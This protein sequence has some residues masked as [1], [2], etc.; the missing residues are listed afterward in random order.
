MKALRR[1]LIRMMGLITRHRDERRLREEVE[2]HLALQTAEN[3]KAGMCPDEARR[4][5]ILKFGAIEAVKESYRD[6]RRLPFLEQFVNDTRYAVRG[7]RQSPGFTTVAVLTLALGIG[8]NSAMFAVVNAV[9]LKPLPFADA[10]R[11][12][13]VH[14]RVPGSEAEAGTYRDSVWSYPKYRTFV[15]LQQTFD[16]TA[17]FMGRDLILAG[18][19][20]PES[21]RGETVTERYPGLLGISPIL[22]RTFTGGGTDWLCAVG[23]PIWR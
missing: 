7:L 17:L 15:D 21:V 6:Q 11:L 16:S 3:L 8:A 2:E 5:A 13:L 22:G 19:N 9:L 23:A 1:F 18:D 10:E 14:L 4:Q 12:M 20:N